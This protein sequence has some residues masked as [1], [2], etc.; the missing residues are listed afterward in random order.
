MK[1]IFEYI[2]NTMSAGRLCLVVWLG[3]GPMPFCSR[4]SL[5]SRCTHWPRPQAVGLLALPCVLP[6]HIEVGIHH[7]MIA[8]VRAQ[9]QY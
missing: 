1:G 9:Q 8:C 2:Y 4:P 5:Q 7:R 6:I 3:D